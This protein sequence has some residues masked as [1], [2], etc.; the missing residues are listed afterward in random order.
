MQ[1]PVYRIGKIRLANRS[2]IWANPPLVMSS[3]RLF[4][5]EKTGKAAHA[6]CFFI[7]SGWKLQA[8]RL[9][10]CCLVF[11][12]R[13]TPEKF[14]LSLSSL[15]LLKSGSCSLNI[16]SWLKSRLILNVAVSQSL[17]F[18]I[19]SS[20]WNCDPRFRTNPLLK[21]QGMPRLDVT[22]KDMRLRYDTFN[23]A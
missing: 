2:Y 15:I 16:S 17:K 14:C 9:T 4:I 8:Y 12:D 10:E 21:R 19:W 22:R 13:L 7:T 18:Y 20:I 1:W 11:L 3:I 23:S 6:T 5:L